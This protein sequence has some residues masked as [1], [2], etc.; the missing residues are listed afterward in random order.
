MTDTTQEQSVI[1]S[2]DDSIEISYELTDHVVRESLRLHGRTDLWRFVFMGLGVICLIWA[3]RT[4]YSGVDGPSLGVFWTLLAVYFITVRAIILWFRHRGAIRDFRKMHDRRADFRC[5]EN[6][7]EI[8][9]EIG[10]GQVRWR[11]LTRVVCSPSIWL[12]YVGPSKKMFQM[13]V[14]ENLTA[15]EKVKILRYIEQAGV[16]IIGKRDQ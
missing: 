4:F 3:A 13:V 9:V 1:G 10:S 11:G 6:G 7:Y 14:T 15:A 2:D 8:T 16:K 5:G 12:L